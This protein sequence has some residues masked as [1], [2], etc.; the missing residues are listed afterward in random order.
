[1]FFYHGYLPSIKRYQSIAHYLSA[2]TCKT[3][4]HIHT[5]IRAICQGPI[6][7]WCKAHTHMWERVTPQLKLSARRALFYWYIAFNINH[8]KWELRIRLRQFNVN[9]VMRMPSPKYCIWLSVQFHQSPIGC[10]VCYTWIIRFPTMRVPLRSLRS[11][12]SDSDP[13]QEFT[14]FLSVSFLQQIQ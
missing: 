12:Q 3:R 13:R 14:H 4:R 8:C 2:L 7:V 6:N 1:M 5:F 10:V 11:A 9:Q